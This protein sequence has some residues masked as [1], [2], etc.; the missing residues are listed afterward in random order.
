M[1]LNNSVPAT[2]FPTACTTACTFDRDLLQSMGCALGEKCVSEEVSVL[3]GPG[4]NIKR[5]PLCGRNFEYFSEDPYLAGEMGAAWVQG[6]QSQGV[7]VSL[8]HFAANSQETL[9]MVSDSVVDE[10]ALREIYLSPFEHTVKAAKPWTVMCSYNRLNGTYAS[11]SAWLLTDVLRRE[12]GFDG[13]VVSDWGAVNDRIAGIMAGLD[14]EMP[15]VGQDSVNAIVNAVRTGT[16]PQSKLDACVERILQLV[17]QAQEP[18]TPPSNN[19]KEHHQLARTI[20]AAGT[21]LLQNK[22]N[23]LPLSKTAKVAFLGRMAKYPRYQGA[24]SSKINPAFLDNALQA[25]QSQDIFPLYADGYPAEGDIDADA[26]A[27]LQQAVALAQQADAAVVFAGLPDSYESEGF[28]RANLSMPDTHNALIA[29][30]AAAN[31]HTVVV[32]QCGA[33]VVLPW[34]DAV[35]GIL[36]QYLAGQAGGSACV[37]VLFGDV[38]PGGHLAETWPLR[39]EDVPCTPWYA[40]QNRSVEYR[41]SIFVGYR[42]YDAAGCAVAYP[43][44]YGLSYTDFSV[45]NLQIN[46]TDKNTFTAQVTVKNTGSRCGSTVVQLYV[47]FAQES[48]ILRAPKELKGFERVTLNPAETAQ[49]TFLLDSR[50]FAYYNTK[51]SGWCIEGGSYN[52]SVGFSSRDLPL[53]AAVEVAGDDMETLLAQAQALPSYHALSVPLQVSRDDFAQLLE[54]ALPQT[55][56]SKQPFSHNSTL[57]DIQHTF[58]GRILLQQ[59]QKNIAKFG[60]DASQDDV[61]RMAQTMLFSM[62][63]RSLA[64]F[65]GGSVGTAQVEGIVALA[66]KKPLQGLRLFLKKNKS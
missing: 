56:D 51:V 65:S 52:V 53:T 28:D 60:G 6:V 64:M 45:E 48:K 61:S 31:P 8:K 46:A 63:L 15:G 50:S 9:R 12:W 34:R 41:E 32:L 2:S 35:D 25:A 4:V 66:N 29:A 3:L 18:H 33:P 59:V 30:V 57:G 38:N 40:T 20:A 13:V 44:G 37:D 58:I 49:V 14:L 62:P 43:F 24:G 10:R 7:G 16:L 55:T 42:Y 54:R 19:N 26:D 22:S 1:G 39:L 47:G 27:L 36:L 11:D 5:S 23:I 17:L 21:V